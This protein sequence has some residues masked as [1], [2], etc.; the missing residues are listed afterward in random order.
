MFVEQSYQ[1]LRI[2][3]ETFQSQKLVGGYESD[4]DHKLIIYIYLFAGKCTK[5]IA[6][7]VLVAVNVKAMVLW[8]VASC[9][10]V[11]TF[12]HIAGTCIRIYMASHP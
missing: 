10:L 6:D 7:E 11:D 3:T 1:Q 9:S 12:L 8:G 5:Y 4:I 2:W